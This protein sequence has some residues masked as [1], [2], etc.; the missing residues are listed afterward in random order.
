MGDADPRQS[1]YQTHQIHWQAR[2]SHH[3]YPPYWFYFS[4]QGNYVLDKV[5]NAAHTIGVHVPENVPEKLILTQRPFFSE[6]GQRVL[7][8]HT[9]PINIKPKQD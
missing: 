9:Q 8:E 7:I 4:E 3:A 6:R 5:I 2:L 1:H